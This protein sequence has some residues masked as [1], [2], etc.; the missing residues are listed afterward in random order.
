MGGCLQMQLCTKPDAEVPEIKSRA[1]C[2]CPR[3]ILQSINCLQQPHTQ[4]T[5]CGNLFKYLGVCNVRRLDKMHFS[6]LPD[7]LDSSHTFG[8]CTHVSIYTSALSISSCC[9]LPC[10]LSPLSAGAPHTMRHCFQVHT[11]GLLNIIGAPH[12][13]PDSTY[14]ATYTHTPVPPTMLQGER[15]LEAK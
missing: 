3:A 4:L 12:L 11:S 2:S 14:V 5:A 8:C 10:P 13:A 15:E 9:L 1:G 6:W 7:L